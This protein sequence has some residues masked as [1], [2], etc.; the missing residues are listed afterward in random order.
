MYRLLDAAES[1]SILGVW[2]RPLGRY[3]QVVGYS[4]LGSL[5][6]NDPN[7]GEYLVLHPLAVGNNARRYGSFT[8]VSQFRQVVLEDP[9]FI[10][11]ILRPA[12][13]AVLEASLGPLGPEEV[14][15][16]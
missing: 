11:E 6:L 5:F 8:A 15:F 13:L 16:P 14:Y 10:E 9:A 12:D 7:S 2:A 1:A 4:W 3:E